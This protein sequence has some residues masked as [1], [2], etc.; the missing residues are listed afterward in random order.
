[1]PLMKR[2]LPVY[3]ARTPEIRPGLH[4]EQW[5]DRS[6]IR[7]S[8]CKATYLGLGLQYPELPRHMQYPAR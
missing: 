2:A 5:G 3:G 7:R 4:G 8:L 6:R 1:M